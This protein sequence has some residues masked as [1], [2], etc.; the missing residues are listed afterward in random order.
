MV[1]H[2]QRCIRNPDRVCGFCLH[3]GFE[4]KPM[5]E[6]IEALSEDLKGIRDLAE[7]CPGCILAAIVQSGNQYPCVSEDDPGFY[8]KYDFKTEV[9]QFW[10]DYRE[11]K[12]SQWV[13]EPMYF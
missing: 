5:P 2:E 10:D 13:P 6:L 8:Y 3:A 4:Q 9:K 1:K 11:S 7:N 12:E